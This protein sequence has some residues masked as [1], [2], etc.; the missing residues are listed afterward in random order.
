VVVLV[1]FSQRERERERE[2]EETEEEEEERKGRICAFCVK[3]EAGI[4]IVRKWWYRRRVEQGTK[5]F[6]FVREIIIVGKR[7][8]EGVGI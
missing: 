4:R 7:K 5:L 3:I 1:F 8:E 6:S 2:R